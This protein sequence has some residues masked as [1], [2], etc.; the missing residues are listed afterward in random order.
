MKLKETFWDAPGGA[1]EIE[2]EYPDAPIKDF[3][4]WLRK[5]SAWLENPELVH[6]RLRRLNGVLAD[7]RNRPVAATVTAEVGMMVK[8]EPMVAPEYQYGVSPLELHGAA[9]DA[10]VR[11]AEEAQ[12]A[13]RAAHLKAARQANMAKAR[14]TAK[15]NR[16]AR[17]AGTL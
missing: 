7:W 8:A 3:M 17:R 13:E 6:R 10:A 16:E 15:A 2:V 12:K 14:A 1:A 11:E 5:T 9:M 4:D